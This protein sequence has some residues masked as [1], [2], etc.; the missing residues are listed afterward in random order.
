MS[1]STG[2][3]ILFFKLL[4]NSLTN[5][6]VF[7]VLR[8]SKPISTEIVQLSCITGEDL[9][10]GFSE[11]LSTLLSQDPSLLRSIREVCSEMCTVHACALI[12]LALCLHLGGDQFHQPHLK[13]EFKLSTSLLYLFLLTALSTVIPHIFLPSYRSY[14]ADPTAAP[15]ADPQ[16]V[17]RNFTTEFYTTFPYAPCTACVQQNTRSDRCESPSEYWNMRVHPRRI[18][19]DIVISPLTVLTRYLQRNLNE[20]KNNREPAGKNCYKNAGTNTHEFQAKPECYGITVD[21]RYGFK[22]LPDRKDLFSQVQLALDGSTV[23]TVPAENQVPPWTPV[24]LFYGDIRTIHDLSALPIFI[25]AAEM[26]QLQELCKISRLPGREP[27][28]VPGSGTVSEAK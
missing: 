15:R 4:C 13:K 24:K 21:S 11:F 14:A 3:I 19:L 16:K 17:C 20:N 25:N 18:D 9:T 2:L 28:D 12:A 1:F 22:G 6:E 7:H 5:G 23:G 10:K 27:G 26:V 8:V